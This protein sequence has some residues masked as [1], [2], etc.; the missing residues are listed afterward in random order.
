[1]KLSSEV[2][3]AA[4]SLCAIASRVKWTEVNIFQGIATPVSGLDQLYGADEKPDGSGSLT[5]L[6]CAVS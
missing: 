2:I 3:C 6:R 5:C 1:M 4:I